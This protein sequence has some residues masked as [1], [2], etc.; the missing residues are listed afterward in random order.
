[1]EVEINGKKFV[2]SKPSGYKLLK[3]VDQSKDT[4]DL[5]RDLIQICIEPKLSKEEIEALEPKDFFVLSTAVT[6]LL[7]DD[8]KNLQELMKSSTK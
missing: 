6:N 1:M 7:A 4:A 5:M 2:L 3:V 8:L